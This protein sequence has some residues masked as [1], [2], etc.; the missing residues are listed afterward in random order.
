MVRLLDIILSNFAI[1]ARP[2]VE[3]DLSVL[4]GAGAAGG[5]CFGLMVFCGAVMKRGI[6]V[7]LVEVNYE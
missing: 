6:D 3:Q 4:P 2:F 5:T 1:K 7:I